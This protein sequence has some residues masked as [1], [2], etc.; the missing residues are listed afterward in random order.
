[1]PGWAWIVLGVV[2]VAILAAVGIALV[3]KQRTT[4]LRRTFGPEYE[5]AVSEYGGQSKAESELESRRRRREELT[6]RPL[7]P[8]ARERYVQQ[9]RSLE[10]RFLDDPGG[11][12]S[13]ADALV[14]EVM[15]ERGY[16]M[17][18]FEQRSA[19][20]SVDHAAV[21]QHYRAAHAISMANAHGRASTEDMRQAVIHYRALFEELLGDRRDERREA[22]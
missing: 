11:A 12:L 4:R 18:D 1:M 7:E 10:A 17:D 3:R 21:V 5:R 22:P 9:W 15:E 14:L 19:D 8:A 13:H 20:I 2:V 16:P 6:I